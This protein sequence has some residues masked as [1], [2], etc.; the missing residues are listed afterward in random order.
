MPATNGRRLVIS[1]ARGGHPDVER[2]LHHYGT[3]NGRPQLVILG[4]AHGVDAQA[5]VFCRR[6]RW[7]FA[8]LWAYWDELGKAAGNERN[9]RMVEIARPG[10][11]FFGFPGPASVG[12]YDARDQAIALGLEWYMA[13]A[14]AFPGP[15]P[16]HP[17]RVA[18]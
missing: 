17:L 6:H 12:T 18:A 15:P 2:W 1:G 13:A 5:F 8:V 14:K 9:G 7:P 10:D 16:R 11:L 3:G 4:D